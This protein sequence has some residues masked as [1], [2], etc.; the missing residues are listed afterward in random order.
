MRTSFF[1]FM[2]AAMLKLLPR[3]QGPLKFLTTTKREF[4]HSCLTWLVKLFLRK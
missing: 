1:L 2:A 3:S 4:G